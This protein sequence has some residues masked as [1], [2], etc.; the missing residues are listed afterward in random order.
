MNAN[1]VM[2][3]VRS[4]QKF[5]HAFQ[6]SGQK[7]CS[8]GDMNHRATFSAL[9]SEL[10]FTCVPIYV[11]IH[12]QGDAHAH[13]YVTCTQSSLGAS[14]GSCLSNYIILI[15]CAVEISY[16]YSWRRKTVKEVF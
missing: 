12:R 9:H 6:P 14:Q 10:V 7:P 11:Y 3:V 5:I 16:I 4:V 2:T 13:I 1:Q 15:G 8:F